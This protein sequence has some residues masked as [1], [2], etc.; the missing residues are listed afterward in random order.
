MGS[1]LG[2]QR[3]FS[4]CELL[5]VVV[6][7]GILAA[8]TI[9]R[10]MRANAILEAQQSLCSIQA[11]QVRYRAEYCKFTDSIQ[12]L[13]KSSPFDL[14]LKEIATRLDKGLPQNYK[15]V[16]TILISDS[17]GFSAMATSVKF[18]DTLTIGTEGVIAKK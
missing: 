9:P 7:I 3:G 11:A 16:Y 1:K 15:I 14:R 5:I 10:F 8:L 13:S 2:S 12:Y 6:I 17:L 18:D 4:L